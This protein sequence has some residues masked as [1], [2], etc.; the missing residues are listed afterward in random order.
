MTYYVIADTREPWVLNLDG[1]ASLAEAKQA[2]RW[3]HKFDPESRWRIAELRDGRLIDIVT[4]ALVTPNRGPYM[5]EVW[6]A[7]V[8]RAGL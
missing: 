3:Q 4:S 2:I 5:Q 1:H 7:F 6:W 8:E